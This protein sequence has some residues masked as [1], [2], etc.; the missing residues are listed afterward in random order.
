[1]AATRLPSTGAD[2]F[3]DGG[4]PGCNTDDLR[5]VHALLRNLY[6]E[7]PQLVRAVPDGELER[8]RF[9]ADHVRDISNGLH[10]HHIGE[11]KVLWRRLETR[12]PSCAVHVAQMREQHAA[13]A[14]LLERLNGELPRWRASGSAEDAE[15]V[16]VALDDI[17][18]TLLPHLG[19]EEEKIA[20]VAATT[21]SQQEWNQMAEH[22]MAA[23]PKNRLLLQ[24]GAILNSFPPEERKRW[25]KESVPTPARVLYRLLGRRQY[26][27]YQEELHRDVAGG[28]SP[29]SD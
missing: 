10:L 21:L 13:V 16:A 27:R 23:L 29:R 20:P 2:E 26:D 7:G 6:T 28:R 14:V 24:L 4:E 5:V 11:D 22:G 9:V 1:M 25:F 3:P 12:A 19:L 8:T 18:T 17:R 15:R